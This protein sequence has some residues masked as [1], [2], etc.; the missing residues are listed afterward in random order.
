MTKPSVT[1]NGLTPEQVKSLAITK[2]ISADLNN[3]EI[4]GY[5]DGA[6]SFY[7]KGEFE[8]AE[9][10]FEVDE[11]LL[12]NSDFSPAIYYYNEESQF[13]EKLPNQVVNGNKVTAIVTHFSKYMLLNEKIQDMVWEYE[14]LYSEEEESFSRMDIVFVID[15]S[16][17]MTSNDP[18]NIRIDVT[19]NFINR[20]NEKDRG[21]I[22]DFDSSAKIL[23]GFTSNKA[24]LSMAAG[25]IDSNGGTNLGAGI[26][27]AINLFSNENYEEEKALKCIIMLTDGD[28]SYSHSL[29]T[30]ALNENIIIYTVGLGNS[31]KSSLLQ[32]IAN[33]TGGSYHSAS[34]ANSLYKIF[35]RIAEESDLVKD[36]DGDGIPDYY[37]KQ[38]AAG[39]LRLGTDRKSVV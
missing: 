29:T 1:I 28:G 20:L 7:V 36:T 21:A 23:S 39:N 38:M 33:G 30:S 10:I 27:S 15:S 26:S 13:L 37:E 8:S 25:N 18:N 31:V 12:N 19:R 9:M 24:T 5:I 4:P 14:I 34:N 3:P 2:V 16:G 6:Y 35:E 32:S 17:S 22:I 11:N